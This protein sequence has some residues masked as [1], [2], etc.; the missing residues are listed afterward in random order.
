[1]TDDSD[2]TGDNSCGVN[3]QYCHK[4]YGVTW[5]HNQNM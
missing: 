4:V 5:T 3:K 1:M 2:S